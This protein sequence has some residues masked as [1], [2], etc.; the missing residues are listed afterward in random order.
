VQEVGGSN[1]LGPTF[2]ANLYP[3][4]TTPMS[5]TKIV[6]AL[7]VGAAVAAAAAVTLKADGADDVV[8]HT[9][10]FGLKDPSQ[11]N[12]DKVVA[13]CRKYA[14][15]HDGTILFFCGGRFDEQSD[16][17]FVD[18]DFQVTQTMIFRNR[19]ALEKYMK[20]DERQQFV[21]ECRS[22]WSKIRVFQVSLRGLETPGLK[23]ID[24]AAP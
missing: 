20:S 9:V 8:A 21:A 1:P 15:K 23:R 16:R 17:P 2:F 12:I 4:R 24:A 19:A 18:K 22:L 13:S 10:Y 5:W 11:A 7:F 3:K 14:T 6:F